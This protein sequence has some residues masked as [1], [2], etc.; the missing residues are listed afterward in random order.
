ML[1]VIWNLAFAHP[2]FNG[3]A[4][5]WQEDWYVHLGIVVI[6][7]KI[8]AGIIVATMPIALKNAQIE[9][10]NFK[11]TVCSNCL[12]LSTPSLVVCDHGTLHGA[13]YCYCYHWI[14]S[15]CV[16][17]KKLWCIHFI[18]CHACIGWSLVLLVSRTCARCHQ[19][20]ATLQGIQAEST[21][22]FFLWFVPSIRSNHTIGHC[23]RHNKSCFYPC[24]CHLWRQ[25]S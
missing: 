6:T 19:W 15:C 11:I 5:L 18:L 25:A 4:A 9:I 21:C 7:C 1:I 17:C 13:D 3:C 2:L 20:T 14:I 22:D 8:L 16:T 10:L 23:P 12:I 24:A